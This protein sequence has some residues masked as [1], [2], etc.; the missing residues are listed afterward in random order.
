[1]I[2]TLIDIELTTASSI[3]FH[4]AFGQILPVTLFEK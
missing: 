2:S 1:M 4:I 3:P